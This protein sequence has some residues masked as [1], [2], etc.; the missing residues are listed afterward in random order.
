MAMILPAS[1]PGRADDVF[2]PRAWYLA[3]VIP[4]KGCM[5]QKATCESG[6]TESQH[7]RCGRTREY[8]R[9]YGKNNENKQ[10]MKCHNN[11]ADSLS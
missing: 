3:G 6:V 4:V 2:A 11:L 9:F 8:E 7:L 1:I 10:E 5:I